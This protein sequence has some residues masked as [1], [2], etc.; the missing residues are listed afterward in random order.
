MVRACH[1][2]LRPS[3]CTKH[4]DLI[5]CIWDMTVKWNRPDLIWLASNEKKKGVVFF[6]IIISIIKCL[7]VI[8]LLCLSP[9]LLRS[10]PGN[11]CQLDK[12]GKLCQKQAEEKIIQV[13]LHKW[14]L[15]CQWPNT[16]LAQMR[17]RERDWNFF[18]A[19]DRYTSFKHIHT[20]FQHT[21]ARPLFARKCPKPSQTSNLY[22]LFNH[23]RI[24][25]H[26]WYCKTTLVT[27]HFTALKDSVQALYHP[28]VYFSNAFLTPGGPFQS[29]AGVICGKI[30]LRNKNEEVKTSRRKKGRTDFNG[31]TCTGKH[32]DS[33]MH[34]L[35]N[36]PFLS[37]F[38]HFFFLPFQPPSIYLPL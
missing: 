16:V 2:Y 33:V 20:A 18:Q 29:R 32:I 21:I 35:R 17:T 14:F 10:R 8:I 27:W 25:S 9:W 38:R 24:Y 7:I 36:G 4:F 19:P 22:L 5:L 11:Y 30:W 23:R 28:V 15:G 34:V 3:N 6:I 13:V 12:K 31:G 1:E 37:W 26:D